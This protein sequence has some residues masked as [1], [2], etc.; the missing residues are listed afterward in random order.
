M[1]KICALLLLASPVFAQQVSAGESKRRMDA[2][3]GFRDVRFETDTT[4]IPGL[5][6][7]FTIAPVRYYHRAADTLKVGAAQL[8]SISYG[9][10]GGKLSEVVLQTKGGFNT[11]PIREAFQAQYGEG[12]T[13][14]GPNYYWGSNK[15]R[16]EIRINPIS[17]DGTF[18]IYSKALAKR[19]KAERQ[20][21]GKKAASDL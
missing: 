15:E 14:C 6:H 13:V 7:V 2:K 4:A 18:T 16:I 19:E 20:Q 10:V 5:K 1:L 11:T 3:Y 21:L 17:Q 12:C 9:F 8:A